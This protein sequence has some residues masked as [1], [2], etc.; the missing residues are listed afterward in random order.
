MSISG[1]TSLTFAHASALGLEVPSLKGILSN[2]ASPPWTLSA[3]TAYMSESHCLETLE[4]LI[5]AEHYRVA[6]LENVSATET[7]TNGAS[8]LCSLW[9][10]MMDAYIMP[11]APREV[12][13][14]ALIR[15]RLLRLEYAAHSVPDPAELDKAVGTVHDLVSD[16]LLTTFLLS[17]AESNSELYHRAVSKKRKRRLWPQVE[18][19]LFPSGDGGTQS[20]KTHLRSSLF[21]RNIPRGASDRD[22]YA[23]HTV[24]YQFTQSI[25]D[26]LSEEN[27][28]E[29]LEENGRPT[30][31]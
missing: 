29:L 16:S 4:F 7:S 18:G 13:L 6:Y 9:L 25:I 14:P 20:P 30:G 12:N 24:L 1:P 31:T 5:E 28:E 26:N 2:T 10:K 22:K 17:A 21:G 27:Y 19:D 11:H 15:D 3:F 23:Q 8:T